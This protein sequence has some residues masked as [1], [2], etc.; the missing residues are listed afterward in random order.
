MGNRGGLVFQAAALV[1]LIVGALL[2]ASSWDGLYD[3]LDLPQAIPALPTQVGGLSLLALAY[4]L[5][6]A[7][8]TTELRRV[9]AIAGVIT[10]GGGA[11]V[12]AVWLLFRGQEDLGIDTQGNV[13]LIV[14]ALVMAALAVG[15]AREAR[16]PGAH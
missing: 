13:I 7:P 1:A 6:S 12:I 5:W 8:G 3:T 15:L 4:V 14:A 16:P 11:V 10:L 9:A 2:L